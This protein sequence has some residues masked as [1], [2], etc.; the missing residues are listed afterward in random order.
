MTI[1]SLIFDLNIHISILSLINIH[2][3]N[4]YN[5]TYDLKNIIK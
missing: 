4:A 5:L 1:Y 2:T 3:I